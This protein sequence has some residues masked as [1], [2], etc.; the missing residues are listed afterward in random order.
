MALKAVVVPSQRRG[1]HQQDV[2]LTVRQLVRGHDAGVHLPDLEETDG[3]PGNPAVW[4][5]V[6]AG[7]RG[8]HIGAAESGAPGHQHCDTKHDAQGHHRHLVRTH[9]PGPTDA[10]VLESSVGGYDVGDATSGRTGDQRWLLWRPAVVTMATSGGY[11]GEDERDGAR[12]DQRGAALGTG[13]DVAVDHERETAVN[14]RAV[15]LATVNTGDSTNYH[16]KTK[17]MANKRMVRV[18]VA[19]EREPIR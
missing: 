4:A 13:G 7:V 2:V 14:A 6:R 19:R 9:R 5:D 17:L 8:A 16:G 11:Y 15:R 1:E 3:G 18:T 12:I 10:S